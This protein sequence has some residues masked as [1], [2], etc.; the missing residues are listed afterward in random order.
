[1]VLPAE[2]AFCWPGGW[3]RSRSNV[4]GSLPAPKITLVGPKS[5][6][7]SADTQTTAPNPPMFFPS[8][9]PPPQRILLYAGARSPLPGPG[10]ERVHKMPL[11]PPLHPREPRTNGERNKISF[12]ARGGPTE[13]NI[14]AHKKSS[15]RLVSRDL[16][17]RHH[18]PPGRETH[19]T[20]AKTTTHKKKKNFR[21]TPTPMRY[22]IPPPKASPLNH[23]AV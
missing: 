5:W 8:I 16:K 22:H 10:S 17:H 19:I 18:G 3:A 9:S 14:G 4:W 11:A 7:A 13:N 15:P 23:I 6:C 20:P 12:G 2:P 1:M 21:T